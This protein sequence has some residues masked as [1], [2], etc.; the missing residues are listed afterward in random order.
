MFTVGIRQHVIRAQFE[1]Q[2][3]LNSD[4]LSRYWDGQA[5]IQMSKYDSKGYSHWT[6]LYQLP[7][8]NE[9]VGTYWIDFLWEVLH[10][11]R[12]TPLS[13]NAAEHFTSAAIGLIDLFL[14][15]SYWEIL[16]WPR[17]DFVYCLQ[18]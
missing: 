16:I 17:V 5:L 6:D 12:K 14:L 4:N 11:D 13:Y 3:N 9:I 2:V 7:I 8:K 15:P 1:L 10:R 18:Y